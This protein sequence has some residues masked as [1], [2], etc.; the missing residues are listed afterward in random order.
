[1]RFSRAWRTLY[2]CRQQA[3][4]HG[5]LCTACEAETGLAITEQPAS[6]ARRAPER[7]QGLAAVPVG[8]GASPGF[9]TTHPA[10]RQHTRHRRRGGPGGPGRGAGGRW[11]GQGGPRDRPLRAVRLACGFSSGRAAAHRHTQRPDPSRQATGGRRSAG[12]RNTSGTTG[13][14]RTPARHSK[15]GRH[16]PTPCASALTHP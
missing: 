10:T 8:G 5:E 11:R 6:L 1:M 3:T 7:P 12:A 15:R 4:A 14:A 9:E 16:Q 13:T 2:R